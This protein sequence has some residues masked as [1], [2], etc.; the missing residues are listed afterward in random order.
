MDEY[1]NAVVYDIKIDAGHV[2]VEIVSLG[3]VHSKI[4]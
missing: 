1:S 4:I 3:S 2:I